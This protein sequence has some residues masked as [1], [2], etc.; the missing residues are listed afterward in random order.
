MKSRPSVTERAVLLKR[1]MI[2]LVAFDM[3]GTLTQHR[4]YI[5][6]D[7]FS[8]LTELS[9]R[10]RIV[11]ASAGDFLRISEQIGRFPADILGNYGMQFARCEK[12]NY[13]LVRE[14]KYSV[15]RAAFTERIRR[16]RA[17][18]GYEQYAGDGVFFY[19]T[20]MATFPVLGTGANLAEKLR[21]DPDRKKRRAMLGAVAEAFPDY[22]V[23]LAGSSSFDI[24]PKAF[25]K[26]HALERY[27]SDCGF[28]KEEVLFV[29]DDLGEGGGDFSV[30][31]AGFR[32]AEVTDYRR[33]RETLSFLEV[34]P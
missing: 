22:T 23:V 1:R 12:G 28:K 27:A 33:L 14:E 26:A 6:S 20:G 5:E 15:D 4:T 32:C 2:K 7:N 24:L 17:R 31:A 25:D 8:L 10:Y 16:L 29:G 18:F 34:K 19:E 30:L 11:I 3:D 9:A 13:R 21:F